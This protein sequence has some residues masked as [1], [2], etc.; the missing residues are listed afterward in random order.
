MAGRQKVSDKDVIALEKEL[1]DR[2]EGLKGQLKRLQATIDS[3]EGNWKGIGAGAFNTK[4]T[5]INESMVRIGNILAGFIEGMTE[6]LKIKDGTE[7]EVRA[8]VQ[9]IDVSLGG[10]TSALSGY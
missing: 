2:F 5:E 3:L 9:S 4:Q 6:T 10:S 1:L 8:Q 7:D